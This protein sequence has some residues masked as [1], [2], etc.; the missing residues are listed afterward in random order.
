[1]RIVQIVNAAVG[2]GA[3]RLVL[4]LH[5]TYTDMGHDSMVIALSGPASGKGIHSTGLSSPYHPLAASKASA[6]MPGGRIDAVHVHLF[7][8]L[9]TVPFALRRR[10]YSGAIFAT[11]HS[12]WNRRRGT[13]RG[14]L[15]DRFTYAPYRKVVC[16]SRAVEDALVSWKPFLQGRTRVISNGV[17][18]DRFPPI[19][20]NCF[21]DPPVILSAGR[22]T[23]AK[24][25]F[26]ALTAVRKLADEHTLPFVWTVA[27]EGPLL[28]ELRREASDLVAAG[29]VRFAGYVD[30]LPELMKRSDIFFMPSS[31]EGFG[32]AAVEAMASG[33]PVVASDVPGLSEVVGSDAGILVDPSDTSAMTD[34]L[35]SLLRDPSRALGM[36][37]AGAVRSRS[38]SIVDCAMEHIRLFTE[39]G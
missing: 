8:A 33:L 28:E 14:R 26:R 1:M 27:G 22:I 17:F 15:L 6:L 39:E 18:L 23:Q 12:T 30:D 11:E 34:A 32:I 16:I 35:R 29:I 36:G 20:R 21:H 31:W 19:V 37:R 25:L 4:D 3:E 10:G 7:P 9:L 13:L 38:Y 5:R 24:N 2:G